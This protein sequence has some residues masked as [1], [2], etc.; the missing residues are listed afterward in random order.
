[1]GRIALANIV[2]VMLM[3]MLDRMFESEDSLRR[4]FHESSREAELAHST[5]KKLTGALYRIE[6]PYCAIEQPL[7]LGVRPVVVPSKC[8]RHA[9]LPCTPTP[10]HVREHDNLSR[11]ANH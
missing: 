8:L 7:V 3:L 1:M 10:S 4:S 11:G 5:W 9:K 2:I 6:T